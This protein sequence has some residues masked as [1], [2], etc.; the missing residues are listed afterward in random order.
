MGLDLYS[1]E[2]CKEPHTKY[3]GS[4]V[5]SL[6]QC[7]CWICY[8]CIDEDDDILRQHEDYDKTT[9]FVDEDG[10][11]ILRTACP[12]CNARR[13]K[14]NKIEKNTKKYRR[15]KIIFKRIKFIETN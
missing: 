6:D 15:H 11:T 12:A 4:T 2:L 10:N 3:G 7:Y 5:Y 14:R 13:E 1:C 8:D 9:E